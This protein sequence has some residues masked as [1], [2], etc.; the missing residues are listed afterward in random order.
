[1]DDL[2]LI[3]SFRAP[4]PQAPDETRRRARELLAAQFDRPSRFG[5]PLVGRRRVL[6]W[7]AAGLLAGLLA[8]SALAFGGRFLDF[9]RG[10]PAPKSVR[11][12]YHFGYKGGSPHFGNPKV[13][14]SRAH[15][16][17]AF[18]TTAGPMALWAAPTRDG[19]V[20]WLLTKLPPG[21]PAPAFG[22]GG[23]GPRGVPG[24]RKLVADVGTLM[25]QEGG[26]TLRYGYG[27]GIAAKDVVR[28]ELRLTNGNVLRANVYEGF[29]GVGAPPGAKLVSATGFDVRGRVVGRSTPPRS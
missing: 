7:V 12:N 25:S 2:Q 15:G 21:R 14:E 8:G 1:M 18:K 11:K 6:V 17:L 10:G 4:A 27:F 29:F 23:C 9:I 16:V 3:K 5:Q 24:G 20:C 19:G 13:I 26:R 22:M 28:V